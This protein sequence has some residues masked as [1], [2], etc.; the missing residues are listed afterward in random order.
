MKNI[1]PDS[2]QPSCGM[3]PSAWNTLWEQAEECVSYPVGHV[4]WEEGKKDSA[5]LLEIEEGEV[6][7]EYMGKVFFC[8]NSTQGVQSVGELPFLEAFFDADSTFTSQLTVRVTAPVKGRKISAV[9]VKT[10]L[11]SRPDVAGKLFLHICEQIMRYNIA[12]NGF[13]V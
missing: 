6:V 11:V 2:Q 7:F 13:E 8:V 5:Y 4:L 3:H 12:A 10:V 9:Q 1:V